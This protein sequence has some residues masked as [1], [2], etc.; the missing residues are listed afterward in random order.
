MAQ[1]SYVFLEYIIP[2][3]IYPTT[4]A[5]R[6]KMLHLCYISPCYSNLT[7]RAELNLGQKPSCKRNQYPAFFNLY[8]LK[9]VHCNF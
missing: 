3:P 8:K 1:T 7:L 4:I 2:F 9:N 6:E 5:L